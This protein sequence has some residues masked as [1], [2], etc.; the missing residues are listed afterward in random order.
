MKYLL[1]LIP[2]TLFSQKLFNDTNLHTQA[3]INIANF[4]ASS[5][6]F[7]QYEFCK[8]V[9]LSLSLLGGFT[10]G[11]AV[12]NAKEDIWDGYLGMGVKDNKDRLNTGY[13]ALLGTLTYIP[14]HNKW[15]VKSKGVDLNKF[16]N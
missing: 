7:I 9:K 11:V 15:F 13:G 3:G 4:G 6:T 14:G 8:E 10:L 12:G 2:F 1:I 16:G 5:I